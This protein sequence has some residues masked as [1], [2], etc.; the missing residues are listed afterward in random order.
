MMNAFAQDAVGINTNTPN[1]SAILD[2]TSTT[3]G[4]LV[5]RMTTAQRDAIGSP[6]RGLLIYNTSTNSFWFYNNTTWI[7][8]ISSTSTDDIQD[9]DGDTRIQV[10]EGA[11]DDIIRFDMRGIEYFRMEDG[12]LEVLNTGNSVFM[13]QNAGNADDLT[14]NQNVFIGNNSGRNNTGGSRNVGVGYRSMND[15]TTGNDN[16]AIG[17]DALRLNKTGNFNLA[18]GGNALDAT[19]AADSNVA[20]GYIALSAL[21]SG[22]ANIGIGLGSMQNKTSGSHNV[23]IGNQALRDNTAGVSNT[24]VGRL[25]G[26]TNTGSRNVFIGYQAGRNETGS[27][28]LYIESSNSATPL[29]W[30]DFSADSVVINGSQHVTSNI[31]YTGTLTGISDRRLKENF[32]TLDNVMPLLNQLQAYSFKMK[33]NENNEREY[34]LIAQEVAK[35]FPEMVKVIDPE[36]NYYGVSY[37]QLIAILVEGLKEQ[38]EIIDS[39]ELKLKHS[40]SQ[41]EGIK[42]ELN[43]IKEI[44]KLK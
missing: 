19:T 4:M 5:P 38:Q 36:H 22:N 42:A 43:E 15:N 33:K 40:D 28:K 32:D 1:A 10:E 27:D 26:R 39:Q 44:V 24:A 8:I 34:G 31:T 29:I 17:E 16:V 2:V 6:A 41:L 23:A 21:S 20:I 30:G 18:L 7:E 25:A 13:G 14:E 11:D 35:V 12:R 3:Q 37:L 9:A